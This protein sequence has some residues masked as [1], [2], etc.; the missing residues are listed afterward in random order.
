MSRIEVIIPCYKYGH[1]LRECVDSVLTQ[2]I[3]DTSVVIVND[4]SPDDTRLI[5]AALAQQDRRVSV[6]DH[7]TNKGHIASYNEALARTNSQY[8]LI[9]SADDLLTPGALER[10]V[11]A[12][13]RHPAVGLCFGDDVPFHSVGA[14]PTSRHAP[15]DAPMTVEDYAS[16]LRRSCSLGHT[17]IQAPTAV[18][19]TAVQRRIGGFV[20]ELPHSADT[21]IWL[22]LAAEGGV[23]RIDADQAYR[24]LHD[25]NMSQNYSPVRRLREQERAFEMHFAYMGAR[26]SQREREDLKQLLSRRLG[27]M[28]FW[29]AARAFDQA[30]GDV[31]GEALEYALT[32]YPAIRREPSFRRMRVKRLVGMRLW[33]TLQRLDL[34]KSARPGVA[35]SR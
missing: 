17:P 27:E 15:A 19:R 7:E 23:A 9:L 24:R 20:P 34:R 8:T 18:M 11:S 30:S 33:R 1:F 13:D 2:S 10:A 14:R 35:S 6:I 16:F 29:I 22:R 32:V 31:V 25:S 5:A 28:S 26:L 12:L 4:A 21:E 3:G